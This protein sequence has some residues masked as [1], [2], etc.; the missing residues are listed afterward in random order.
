MALPKLDV[1]IFELKLLSSDKQINF[2]PFL[3][4]EQKLLLMINE[5]ED[6]K[7]VVKIVK[8]IIQNC[9]LSDIDVDSL[10]IFDLEYIFLNLRA[11]SVGEIVKLQYRCN[12]VLKDDNGEN[13]NCNS[14]EKYEID[15]TKINPTV[16]KK[17]DKKILF[18]ENVGIVMKYPTFEDLQTIETT[19]ED[20]IVSELICKCIDYIF[21]SENIYYAKDH[22]K[23]ELID[24]IDNLQQKDL[25]KIQNFFNS[26]P[27]IRHTIDFKCKKC[28]YKEDIVLE[29][30]QSFFV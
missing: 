10:P 30:L 18:S 27:K 29:G 9:I 15:L 5:S 19:K 17:Q 16:E 26:T 24:F 2:R 11:R 20:V 4:K 28:G 14:I 8:Q 21:D 12:N 22:S 7:E 25:E 23:E 3:V 1:P 6:G 13:V